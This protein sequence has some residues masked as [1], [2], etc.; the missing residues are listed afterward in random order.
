MMRARQ[1]AFVAAMAMGAAACM[2]GAQTM[3]Q[4]LAYQRFQKCSKWPTIV[5]QR[6]NTD[7]RVIVTGRET[8]Q[9][10]FLACMAEQGREQQKIKPDL[11]VPDP[12]VDLRPR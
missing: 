7:G 12:I 9:Y 4:D 8:E 1:A 5:L 6:I 3:E 2:T 11:V 10:Q